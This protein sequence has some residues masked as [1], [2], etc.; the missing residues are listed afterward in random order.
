MKDCCCLSR[1]HPPF[2]PEV[3][4]RLDQL[5]THRK[6]GHAPAAHAEQFACCLPVAIRRAQGVSNRNPLQVAD[7]SV[8]HERTFAEEFSCV[9][10]QKSDCCGA[11]NNCMKH[12]LKYDAA[13]KAIRAVFSDTSVSHAQTREQLEE[14]RELIAELM[15]ALPDFAR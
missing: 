13:E 1:Q 15:E 5:F 12:T 6:E 8:P 10:S 14:L 11:S 9:K 7:F 4:P 3:P 2:L